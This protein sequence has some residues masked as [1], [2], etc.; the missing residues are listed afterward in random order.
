MAKYRVA[1][2]E[3]NKLW[4]FRNIEISFN[5]DISIIIG[6][7]ASGKTTIINLLQYALTGNIIKLAS[8]NF[9]ELVIKLVSFEGASR[10]QIKI[11]KQ[12][13]V[14]RF[15]LSK[16]AFEFP[17]DIINRFEQNEDYR[18][19]SYDYYYGKMVHFERD[20]RAK[21]DGLL[22]AV[23]LP[24]S[25]RLPIP[26]DDN[27]RRSIKRTSLESVDECLSELINSLQRYRIG[28]DA[29]LADLRKEFQ[30]HA[31]ENI[32]YDKQHDR[33]VGNVEVPTD[34]DKEQLGKAF[35]DLGF[36]DHKMAEKI[37]DH[38]KEAKAA[39]EKYESNPKRME[40]STL[41]IFPLIGRTKKMVGFAQEL[42]EKRKDL[43]KPL[44]L[45]ENIVNSFYNDKIIAVNDKGNLRISSKDRRN[46]EIEWKYLSS[47]EKQ[48]L[49]LLTQAL[50]WEDQPIVYVADEP[51]LSLHV[52]WQEKLIKSIIELAGQCQ[53]IVA[54]HSPDISGSYDEKVIDL[55]RI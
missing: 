44:R 11:S 26:E 35:T 32:L 14:L 4:G 41:M 28:L 42:E 21:L 22:K 40:I 2:F 12:N 38:F 39:I 46:Q 17:L 19:F 36:L 7:N 47:G 54:T 18:P 23:W 20:L 25:R 33:I 8:Y 29:E 24:V 48:I 13:G 15:Q 1:Q 37:N 43:F 49:I 10:R 52:T 30:R 51:E 6:P 3:V 9:N 50:L 45:F 34:A 55:S 5:E 27:E 31:L 53:L 16:E